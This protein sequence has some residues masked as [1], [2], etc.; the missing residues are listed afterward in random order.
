M[1]I[2]F[3]DWKALIGRMNS[4][5]LGLG[6]PIERDEQGYNKP[7]FPAGLN[8]GLE[9]EGAFLADVAERL[10]K[11]HRQI[12][13]DNVE[14]VKAGLGLYGDN[15]DLGRA[16]VSAIAV[17]G[18]AIVFFK[19]NRKFV[20]AIKRLPPRDRRFDYPCKG[21]VV[22]PS[23]LMQAA[24]L[25]EQA[26][27][28]V[29]S[30]RRLAEQFGPSRDN[31][32]GEAV[33]PSDLVVEIWEDGHDLVI[34]H[35]FDDAMN[36]AYRAARVY[37][38]RATRTRRISRDFNGF[39]TKAKAV[40]DAFRA[41]GEVKISGVELLE[42]WA[43]K[44]E[45]KKLELQP[46]GSVLR[47]DISMF[48]FQIDGVEFIE[49]AGYKCI[50]GD[51]MGLGKTVQA[52]VAAA[53]AGLRT[54][55]VCPAS[56]KYN[57]AREIAKFTNLTGYVA[58]TIAT[59]ATPICG[60]RGAMRGG[61]DGDW[62]SHAFTIVNGDI[63]IDRTLTEYVVTVVLARAPKVM[64]PMSV[65]RRDEGRATS[66]EVRKITCSQCKSVLSMPR[67][68]ACPTCKRK[69]DTL[70]TLV[71]RNG[72]GVGDSVSVEFDGNMVAG[73]VTL[74][75]KQQKVVKSAWADR[76]KTA[77]FGLLI[78]DESQYYKNWKA[79]RTRRLTEIAAHIDRRIELT[80]TVIKSK[81]AE[82]YSQLRLVA[83]RL[84]GRFV[85]YA[86]R[87][88]GGYR[89]MF[90]F[91]S[92]GATNL[93]ELHELIK[94]VYLRRLKN[95]VMPDLPPK[96][97][98]DIPVYMPTALEARYRRAAE[99]LIQ[100]L[101][102]EGDSDAA[103]RA[104]RAEHLVRIAALKQLVLPPKI[105]A[106]IEFVHNANGQGEKVV[107]F[108]G[109]TEVIEAITAEFGE[110]C[111]R[112]TGSD[113]GEARDAAV[114]SFQDNPSIMVFAG[115]IEAAG[116]GITL[117]ASSKV[118]FVDEPWTPGDKQQ[119]EDRCHRIGQDDCVNVYTLLVA[120]T[121]DEMIHIVLAEKAKVVAAVQDGVTHTDAEIVGRA[122]DIIG[123][124]TALMRDS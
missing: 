62:R 103:Q 21:W 73:A 100:Y 83:P 22:T 11:Y 67:P 33:S 47:D 106:A 9:P 53:R 82:L 13:T 69:S 28:N 93:D 20:A 55:V 75:K 115:N 77:G 38:D 54:L 80:G 124:V 14:L 60:V 25:L 57:W 84:A 39:R 89:D 114:C 43:A 116:V 48:P 68:V 91:H 4:L 58:T 101:K 107:V 49:H 104:Q 41:R 8:A 50:I 94:P 44:A 71:V 27:G 109:Y 18:K 97:H 108:S 10:I 81:P 105:K 19:Y 95:D 52:L 117:T 6:A 32:A 12:G 65:I 45:T 23:C 76:L 99:D 111:V 16:G 88:C 118:L 79:K 56:L 7:D 42:A 72:L 36:T 5:L 29:A 35:D 123:E 87:Y 1:D 61:P 122:I 102:E 121:I 64:A 113:S 26:G 17:E 110:S 2:T 120:D 70:V 74:C 24:D 51:E 96:L 34:R 66:G 3:D 40:L 85:Q 59:D 63:L 15:L 90:G 37:F 86:T 92:D 46:I 30:V 119:A 112:L 78:V 98:S 31:G